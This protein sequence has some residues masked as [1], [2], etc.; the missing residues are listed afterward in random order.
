MLFV[1]GNVEM[2]QVCRLAER[3]LQDIDVGPHLDA[4]RT[5]FA[6]PQM[7]TPQ[8]VVRRRDTHQ[9]HV[10]IGTRC[11]GA[12]DPRQTSLFMLNNLL[13]GP[14]MS[15]RLN[16]ALRERNGLVYTVE[17]NLVNY[18]DTGVWS[19][20]FGCDHRDVNRCR[21]L[22]LHE[23]RRL[24]EAPLS[25]RAVEAARRQL[26]GQIGTSYD[27]A[28]NVAIGMAKRF[29][30]YGRTLTMEQMLE[31]LDGLTSE[32]LWLTAQE[33]FAPENLLTLEYR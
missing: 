2:K 16:M 14:G 18:T 31:R 21:R 28:E 23:L 3:H 4:R 17:S 20:Y 30:H 9:A 33:V 32:R 15:S 12:E 8:H 6:R 25:A 29:L 11:F 13:G 27:N 22:V 1:Y 19:V 24:T 5:A 26:R 10:M 7:D